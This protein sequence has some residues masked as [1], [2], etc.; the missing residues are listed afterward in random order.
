[1]EKQSGPIGPWPAPP[2]WPR[3]AAAALCLDGSLA[4]ATLGG[5]LTACGR[6]WIGLLVSSPGTPARAFEA[7]RRMA[8]DRPT[9]ACP[10]PAPLA[11]PAGWALAA[12][13]ARGAEASWLALAP[14][15]DGEKPLPLRMAAADEALRA[16]GFGG[17]YAPLWGYEPVALGR[18]AIALGV[19]FEDTWECRE[20]ARC[21][22]CPGCVER[23]SMFR[24]L[25][26]H[27]PLPPNATIR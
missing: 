21:G 24:A 5:W 9:L 2:D 25:G 15:D 22:A 16:D 4:S 23:A 1:M 8:G 19:P 18:L 20:E 6:D 14:R 10:L 13:V 7:A 27:D 26:I 12:H 17:I 11:T 3:G